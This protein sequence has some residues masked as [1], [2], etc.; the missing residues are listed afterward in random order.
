MKEATRV[1]VPTIAAVGG[2]F[3]E[4]VSTR[5]NGGLIKISD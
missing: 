3:A 4:C 2:F 5:Q 1:S